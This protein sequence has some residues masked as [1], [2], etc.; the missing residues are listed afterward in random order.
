MS[1]GQS[2]RQASSVIRSGLVAA[3]VVATL[4]LA[5]L[6]QHMTQAEASPLVK[7]HE[8]S[9]SAGQEYFAGSQSSIRCEVRSVKSLL[10]TSPVSGADVNVS[11]RAKEGQVVALASTRTEA[12]GTADIDFKIP[13]IPAGPY[14]L[15]VVTKS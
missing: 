5:F 13:E 4:A 12:N 7:A 3:G 2:C 1:K 14:T 10:E 8:T 15:E 6:G 9:L 11:L